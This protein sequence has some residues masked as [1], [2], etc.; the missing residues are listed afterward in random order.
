MFF[1]SSEDDGKSLQN[2]GAR[3]GEL[4]GPHLGRPHSVRLRVWRGVR[5]QIGSKKGNES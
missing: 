5:W 2:R 4:Q 1:P 3:A